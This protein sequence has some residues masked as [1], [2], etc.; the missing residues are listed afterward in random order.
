MNGSAGTIDQ[1]QIPNLRIARLVSTIIVLITLVFLLSGQPEADKLWQKFQLAHRDGDWEEIAR[2]EAEI[3]KL[4]GVR[5]LGVNTNGD[6]CE[7]DRELSRTNA[8]QRFQLNVQG[9]ILELGADTTIADVQEWAD[10]MGSQGFALVRIPSAG[11]EELGEEYY[12]LVYSSRDNLAIIM[13]FQADAV[14]QVTQ[15]NGAP[16]GSVLW[17]E[18]GLIFSPSIFG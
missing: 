7:L 16:A 6:V 14:G 11:V 10:S 8:Y 13:G 3:K 5:L 17:S 2:I 12:G 4:V 18:D 9:N 15:V 1:P